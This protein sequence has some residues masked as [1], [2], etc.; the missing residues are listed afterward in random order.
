M[1]TLG[2]VISCLIV[3]LA[4]Y[5]LAQENDRIKARVSTR[6]NRSIRLRIS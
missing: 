6:P 2:N 5:T 4:T 3:M 1:R